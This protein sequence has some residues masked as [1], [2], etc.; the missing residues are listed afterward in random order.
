MLFE[1][2]AFGLLR[3]VLG[4]CCMNFALEMLGGI[5]WFRGCE[6]EE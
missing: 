6:S 5:R 1:D 2:G 4:A 3:V